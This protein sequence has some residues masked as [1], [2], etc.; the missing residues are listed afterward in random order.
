MAGTNTIPWCCILIVCPYKNNQCLAFALMVLQIY[1]NYG[2]C[3]EPFPT[4]CDVANSILV[5]YIFHLI[6]NPLSS[7]TYCSALVATISVYNTHQEYAEEG[8]R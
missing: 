2:V 3:N 7:G 5:F 8:G 1:F 4:V 6:H